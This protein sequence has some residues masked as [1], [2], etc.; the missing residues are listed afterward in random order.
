[1]PNDD[2]ELVE[3]IMQKLEDD[4]AVVWQYPGGEVLAIV[5]VDGHAYLATIRQTDDENIQVEIAD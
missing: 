2:P 4:E 1:M 5:D 3:R